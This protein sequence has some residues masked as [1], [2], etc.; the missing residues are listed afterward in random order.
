MSAAKHNHPKKTAAPQSGGGG[1]KPGASTP[2]VVGEEGLQIVDAKFIAA[3]GIGGGSLP[4][5]TYTEIAFCGRSN[6]GKSS[7]I[8]SLVERR[9]LVRTSSTPGCTRQVNLFEIRARDG[10]ALVLADLPGYGFAKRSKDERKQWAELIEGYLRTR[11][12]LATIVVLFDARRGL[13]EDDLELVEFALA[14]RERTLRPLSVVLVATKL[15]KVP[16]S[17]ERLVLDRLKRDVGRGV[18]GY[19]AVTGDGRGAVWRALRKS[20][21]GVVPTDGPSEPQALVAPMTETSTTPDA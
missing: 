11:A 16:R 1:A 17:Q 13:E 19:S 2:I 5:P 7:L 14:P 9:G 10:L 20:A 21:I 3:V 8:N 12:S 15:D 4:P 18:I 6:V